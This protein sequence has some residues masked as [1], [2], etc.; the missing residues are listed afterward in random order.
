[1]SVVRLTTEETE[2]ALD[3]FVQNNGPYCTTTRKC[4]LD[5]EGLPQDT[6]CALCCALTLLKQ[7]TS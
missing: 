3:R 7:K 2:K 6:E 1:M 5:Y 4:S